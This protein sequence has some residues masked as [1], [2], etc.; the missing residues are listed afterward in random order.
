[1]DKMMD[2]LIKHTDEKFDQVRE[3]LNRLGNKVEEL[4]T[5]KIEMIASAKTSTYLISTIVGVTSFAATVLTVY[6][7][8]K[9]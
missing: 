8:V 9:K 6:Y 7:M 2:Y 3:E 5:F 4:N 1:M